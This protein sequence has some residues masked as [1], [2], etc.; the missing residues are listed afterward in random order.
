MFYFLWEKNE[1]FGL[2]WATTT[3]F[4]FP[5]FA[6]A[7]LGRSLSRSLSLSLNRTCFKTCSLKFKIL[8]ELPPASPMKLTFCRR[9]L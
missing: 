9:G 7:G 4:P 2:F 3:G 6:D 1:W 8:G 5:G